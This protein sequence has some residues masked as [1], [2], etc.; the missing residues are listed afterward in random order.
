MKYLKKFNENIENDNELSDVNNLK[1]L[2]VDSKSIKKQ[3][4]R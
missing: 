4:K 3:I 1:Q 2:L